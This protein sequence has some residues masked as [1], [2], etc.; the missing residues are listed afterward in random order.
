MSNDLLQKI[1]D[2]E[3]V[4]SGG[5]GILNPEQASRFIDYTWDATV[6]GNYAQRRPMANPQ[7]DVDSFRVGQRITRLATEGLDDG[8][9]A[10]PTFGKVT[11][12]TEKLRL[13]W[14]ITTE[15]LEDNLAGDDL[16]DQI[17]RAMATT[18]GNDLE[19]VAINGDTA[20]NTGSPDDGLI[21][22]YDGFHK[23][24]LNGGHVISNNGGYLT[25][26]T[27]SRAYK[28]LP[29]QYKSRRDAM[30]FFT[31]SSLVHD[32]RMH[33]ANMGVDALNGTWIQQAGVAPMVG[34][35]GSTGL[36]PFGIE[37]LDIPL[38]EDTFAGTYLLADAVTDA[39][40]TQEYHGYVDLTVPENMVWGVHREITMHSRFEQRKDAFE[41]TVFTRQGVVITNAD[42]YVTV[43]DVRNKAV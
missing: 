25:E 39:D 42:A 15:S 32:F 21:M 12:R 30:K 26:E 7:V 43:T 11:L 4:G 16:Q 10:V 6:L 28:Q 20:V 29:R 8:Q 37:L 33:L 40:P 36:R 5:G 24:A 38:Y 14:E 9:N 3:L 34:E 35:Q 22:A 31:A 27:F 18:L 41:F 23:L 19:D 13:D 1:V 17:S 2:T